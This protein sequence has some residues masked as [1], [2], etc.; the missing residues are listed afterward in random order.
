MRTKPLLVRMALL[1]FLSSL[2]VLAEEDWTRSVTFKPQFRIRVEGDDRTDLASNRNFGLLRVRPEFSWRAEAPFSMTFTP[3]FSRTLGEQTTGFTTNTATGIPSQ[4]SGST[5]DPALGV[6]EAYVN[7]QPNEDFSLKGGRQVLSYGDE[8]II[9]ALEW[10]NVGRS[11]D[12]FKARYSYAGGFSDLFFSKIIDNNTVTPNNGGDVN[13]YGFYNSFDLGEAAKSV[14]AYIFW[15]QDSSTTPTSAV[16]T[17]A[18]TTNLGLF[19][20]RAA[21]HI[22]SLDYRIEGTIE[23]GSAVDQGKGA[24]QIDGELG[25]SFESSLK[26]RLAAGYFYAGRN[27]NQLYPTTHKWLG[28]ADV[29]GRRNIRGFAVHASAAMSDDF[30]VKIDF[31]SFSRA[32]NSS[33]AYKKLDTTKAIG[34]ASGSSSKA[35]GLEWDVTLTYKLSKPVTL[36]AGASYFRS[37]S[38]ITDQMPHWNPIFYFTQVEIKL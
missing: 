3:Q 35:L 26:P 33:P 16:G 19:G 14:D 4:S 28:Y 36:L 7:Y 37:G 12:A 27:Y 20:L 21:S 24:Q 32:S 29:V 5:V 22:R 23:T 25:Y 8:L 34:T 1:C 38:Y 13:L 9:G 2:P 30:G 18:P 10:N 11:F 31:Y 15:K 17:L 6:H